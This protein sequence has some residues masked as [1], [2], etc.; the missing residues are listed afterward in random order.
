[1]TNEEA[2]LALAGIERATTQIIEAFTQA[3]ETHVED[4]ELAELVLQQAGSNI[5]EATL[6]NHLANQ[7]ALLA[8]AAERKAKKQGEP[9][10]DDVS[11]EDVRKFLGLNDWPEERF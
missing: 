1:M 5:L 3:I 6:R 4:S 10:L 9:V 2:A 8:R 7:Q 11:A